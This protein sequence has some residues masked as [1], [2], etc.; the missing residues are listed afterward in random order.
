M[1]RPKSEDKRN[2]ILR[3]AIEV[4]AERGLTATPTAAISRLAGVAEG[5]LF[6]YFK[7]KDVL[8]NELYLTIKREQAA[9][10]MGGLPAEADVREQLRHVWDVYVDWGVAHPATRKAMAQLQVSGV[11][12]AESL[13][14]GL[15][16][17]ARLQASIRTAIAQD[18]LRPLPEPFV[19]AVMQSLAETTMA[20]VSGKPEAAADYRRWGFEVLWNGIEQR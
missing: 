8:V 2:A 9:T 5:T 6:T 13:S 17:F 7:T 15:A 1:A 11:L 4:I 12:T 18:R 19:E 14:A 10:C 20:A 16:P 3:A